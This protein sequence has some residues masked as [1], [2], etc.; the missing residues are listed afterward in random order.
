MTHR[1]MISE[2]SGPRTD[3]QVLRVVNLAKHYDHE[4]AIAGVTFSVAAGEVL[5]LVGP[6][7]AGK[8]TLLE[9]LAGLLA[10]DSG[11]VFWRG[12]ELPASRR[13]DVLFYVP[14]GVKPYQDRFAIEV[15]S[16][17][18]NVYGRSDADVATVVASVGLAP[19]LHKRVH[20]L[21]KGYSR[22]LLLALGF[23]TPHELLLMDEPFDGFDLLQTRSIIEVVRKEA[24]KGRALILAIHQLADA[25]RVCDRLILFAGG[26]LRGIG[27]LDELRAQTAKHDGSLEEIFLALT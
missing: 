23:L 13:K 19:V 27:T 16:L 2:G 20:A 7:G 14:D 1:P 6:N 21:S 12:E 26:Q 18:A 10:L 17:F 22:R 11:A 8:T 15:V 3:A 5:G 24:A 9:G 4:Q 25:Q